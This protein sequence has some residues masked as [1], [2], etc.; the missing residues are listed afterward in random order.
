[1]GNEDEYKRDWEF[2]AITFLD[3][4][5]YQRN[6]EKQDKDEYQMTL[7]INATTWRTR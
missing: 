5:E 2:E 4:D 1:M 6:R 3:E 7:Q